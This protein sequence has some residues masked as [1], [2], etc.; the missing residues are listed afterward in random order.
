LEGIASFS[1]N[2]SN[3]SG[4]AVSAG[5]ALLAA[6]SADGG[7]NI[8]ETTTQR[9][10]ANLTTDFAVVDLLFSRDGAWLAGAGLDER[11]VVWNLPTR[12]KALSVSRT[13]RK[14]AVAFLAG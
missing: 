5:G 14:G 9:T 8:I 13:P 11:V 7:V 2:Q 10:V 3:V 6:A 4:V 12:E 1:L